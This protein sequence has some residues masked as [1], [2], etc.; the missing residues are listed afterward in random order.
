M[1]VSSSSVVSG[2]M[3]LVRLLF[4]SILLVVGLG[5]VVL[6]WPFEGCSGIATLRGPVPFVLLKALLLLLLRRCGS[7]AGLQTSITASSSVLNI[8][9]VQSPSHGSAM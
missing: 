9:F 4:A 3:G 5:F 6:A 1:V 8:S 7:L 2:C